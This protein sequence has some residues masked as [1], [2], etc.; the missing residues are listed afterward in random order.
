MISEKS[1]GEDIL[2]DGR[3]GVSKVKE[4]D[5]HQLQQKWL[6]RELSKES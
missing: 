1:K 3:S 4:K 5:L 2:N 6:G